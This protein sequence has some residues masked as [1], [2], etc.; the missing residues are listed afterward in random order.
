MDINKN[1]P[2]TVN[3]ISAT[4]PNVPRSTN[5]LS[6]YIANSFNA[7]FN[8]VIAY[9]KVMAGERHR[10]YRL[11]AKFQMLTPL[12]PTY[13]N[14]TAT[15]RTYFV[16]NS[17]VWT[18]AEKYTAQKK[19][20]TET[21]IQ[22]I[23]NLYGKIIKNVESNTT[24]GKYINIQE[25]TA[26]RDAWV[27]S[28]IPKIANYNEE[29]TTNTE[30]AITLPKLSV[31]PLRGRIA[32][33]NDFERNKSYA[34][35]LQEFKGDTVTSQEWLN[36]TPF[37]TTTDIGEYGKIKIMNMRAKRQ[38]SYYS[39]YRLE[40]QGLDTYIDP[41]E[42]PG[43]SQLTD[44]VKWENLISESRSQ[45]ENAQKNDWDI[46][47]QIR[48]SKKLTEGKVQLIGQKS[49]NLNYAAIT[50]NAYNNN[51]EVQEEFRVLGKQGAYSYT[52]IDTSCYA[53]ME[54]Y[55]EGYIHVII[56]VSADNVYESVY[57]RMDLNVTPLDEYRPDL[58]KQKED[59]LYEIECSVL[60]S[61]E[62]EEFENVRGFKRKFSEYFK[63]P[64]IIRGDMMNAPIYQSGKLNSTFNDLEYDINYYQE[65]LIIPNNTFQFF[66]TIDDRILSS[67]GVYYNKDVYLDYSDFL[68]NKN[69]AIKNQ[70]YINIET[71]NAQYG[72][73]LGGQNQIFMV[74]ITTCYADMPIDESIKTNYTTWGEH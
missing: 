10:E 53:G 22:E 65:K 56:T 19:N 58:V 66:E 29:K 7:G 74:G 72:G 15:I 8:K 4:K 13:Q 54:F 17:R 24:Q 36:Y 43:T 68:V 62:A 40:L 37:N 44:W 25:T 69:Q 9:K 34:P 73:V 38:N 33:Y 52:E 47:A 12:T 45:V 39:D 57:D 67:D 32:I 70:T 16:P 26:W 5:V 35:A 14:L 71:G 28:Y 27:S 42:S 50:Q 49:F 1:K 46:I 2:Y 55:E 18:N 61:T 23:P 41:N 6:G 63:L 21:K 30:G 20:P 11:K 59:V 48:G 31:L 60:P 64:N 51:E 3:Q